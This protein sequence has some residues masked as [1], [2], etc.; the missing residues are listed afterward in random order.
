MDA[1][2]RL[3]EAG[4]VL[5]EGGPW[6]GGS[7]G[8]DG[9][10]GGSGGPGRNPWGG[11]G[12][13]SGKPGPSAL[14]ALVRRGRAR[15]G[16]GGG[17]AGGNG[18]PQLPGAIWAW[19]ILGLVLLWMALTSTHTIG[20]QQR[21]VVTRFG[22][23][24]GMLQPGLRFSLPAPIDIVTK[25]DVDNIHVVDIDGGAAGASGQNL[26]LTGDE[27]LID[28]AYSVRW[29]IRDPELFMFE[30]SDPEGT[31]REVA[32]SAMREQISNVTLN[33]AIGPQRAIIEQRV[34]LRMQE[35][36]DEYRAG[37][38]VQGV[39]I[40]Q[41][42]PPGEVMDAF[43]E[44]SAAQQQAQSY[45]NQARAY[46]TQKTA[47]AQGE[48]AAFD[49]VYQQY[50]LAPEV[51]RRRLYYETMEKVLAKTDKTVLEA[52]GVTPYLPIP[53]KGASK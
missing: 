51:T 30:L 36:L 15:F 34:A 20:P 28:L 29:N 10:G 24:V 46:A 38:A 11:G 37:V 41:A 7:G 2:G 48:A 25:I 39:A 13:P 49:S 8:G 4:A 53:P 32:E 18:L 16:G 43:K 50:K 44:V 26:M 12:K 31:I 9:A 5:N 17:G 33:A 22:K 35:L 42:D 14:D 52:P 21:G 45:L 47:Q 6:G 3:E 1:S 27:N 23:Y 19:G 40:K